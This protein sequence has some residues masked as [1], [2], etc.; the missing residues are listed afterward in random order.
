MTSWGIIADHDYLVEKPLRFLGP[1][2][3][4]LVAPI[5]LIARHK[6]YHGK[7]SFVPAQVCAI[8]IPSPA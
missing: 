5:Y 4:G 6:V 3:K 8:C 2:L 1:M 7:L